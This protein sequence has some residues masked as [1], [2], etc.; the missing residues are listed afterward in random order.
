[1]SKKTEKFAK[2]EL[3][4]EEATNVKG[5][6]RALPETSKRGVCVIKGEP[7]TYYN[8]KQECE[9]VGGTWVTR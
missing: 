8:T 5:G 6:Y 3:S 2:Q 9:S 7:N 1:M 4:N